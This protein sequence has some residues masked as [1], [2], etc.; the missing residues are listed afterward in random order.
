MVSFGRPE[1]FFL[2]FSFLP[3]RSDFFFACGRPSEKIDSDPM[4]RRVVRPYVRVCAF[5]NSSFLVL[6]LT[7]PLP[8]QQRI[9]ASLF[10]ST[11]KFAKISPLHA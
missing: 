3:F 10:V 1:L 5:A 2:S 9:R 7:Y 8:A 11:S 6:S 4:N